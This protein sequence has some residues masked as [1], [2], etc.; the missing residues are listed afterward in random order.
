MW[1]Y[2]LIYTVICTCML[3]KYQ[4]AR[5]LSNNA[6]A[7][8]KRR[9]AENKNWQKRVSFVSFSD[10]R[11]ICNKV[12]DEGMAAGNGVSL[13]ARL[14]RTHFFCGLSNDVAVWRLTVIMLS[15]GDRQQLF[16]SF[17]NTIRVCVCMCEFI[18]MFA[19]WLMHML[20]SLALSLTCGRLC[21]WAC[22][23]VCAANLHLHW[24][25]KSW[26]RC[27]N[28]HTQKTAL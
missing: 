26:H 21:E 5:Q 20:A 14:W 25:W 19:C 11:F 27:V 8:P 4:L 2:D 18:S 17:G 7:Q 9:H 3:R 12:A 1:H 15:Q 24:H 10:F 13:W 28:T 6:N 22:V 23:C 16:A